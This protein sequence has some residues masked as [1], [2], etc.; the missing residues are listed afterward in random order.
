MTCG[1]ESHVVSLRSDGELAD[2]F[3]RQGVTVEMLDMERPNR[4]VPALLQLRGI[5]R[6][7]RPDV[8][9][10]WMYH[11]NIVALAVRDLSGSVAPVC[12]NVRRGLDDFKERKRTTQSVIRASAWVSRRVT[13]I[14]Y[15][16]HRSREQ[17]TL[18]GFRGRSSSVVGNGFDTARFAPS[19]SVRF[20]TRRELGFTPSDFV[21]GTVGR[22]DVAKG[23]RYLLE[24][25]AEVAQSDPRVRLLF[26]GRGVTA[27]SPGL[28][29]DVLPPHV[30][31]RIRFERERDDIERLYPALD[32]YCSPSIAEGF[33]NVIA[34]AASSGL[35]ILAS[36][37]GASAELVRGSGILV[38]PRSA[39]ELARGISVLVNEDEATR[40]G[41]GTRARN[42]IVDSYSM[43]AVVTA[44]K[45]LYA[46]LSE[47]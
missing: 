3:R 21:I 39:S 20:E 9:Q 31:S 4:V 32:L 29:V 17:H 22:Y 10:G 8:I 19:Q 11:A 25:F 46:S 12:W 33:P 47:G 40:R 15:C 26:V 38:Q 44:Y 34:E 14:V 28:S 27:D 6:N 23:H 2:A 42:V 16:S 24:A 18:V 41:R 7:K 36:D 43:G 30:R 35:P 37:T 1:I 45:R 5:I 13:H